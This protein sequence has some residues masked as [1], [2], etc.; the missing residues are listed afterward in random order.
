[1]ITKLKTPAI[2]SFVHLNKRPYLF[3]KA[4]SEDQYNYIS[5]I[6]NTV[7]KFNRPTFINLL[8]TILSVCDVSNY[9]IKSSEVRNLI[10]THTDKSSVRVSSIL[11]QF[12]TEGLKTGI[13]LKLEKTESRTTIKLNP[14]FFLESGMPKNLELKIF[15][16]NGILAISNPSITNEYTI[17]EMAIDRRSY[18]DLLRLLL[19]NRVLKKNTMPELIELFDENLNLDKNVMEKEINLLCLKYDITS[20]QLFL[21]QFKPFVESGMVERVR[22]STGSGGAAAISYKLS[23]DFFNFEI[24][25]NF[26]LHLRIQSGELEITNIV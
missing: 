6:T 13:F 22:K 2:T 12:K 4:V 14:I 5:R 16:H 21:L 23:P 10:A 24:E 20:K 19:T 8:L 9:K 15:N 1:M 7:T 18:V 26:N 25:N 17:S 11:S 3:G